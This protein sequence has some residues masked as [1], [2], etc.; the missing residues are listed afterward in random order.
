MADPHTEHARAKINLALH[1]LG[2]R[3]GGYHELDSI[4]GFADVAD[5][6][7]FFPADEFSL[8]VTGP[9]AGDVP[10]GEENIAMKAARMFAAAFSAHVPCRMV[11]EK[12][13]PVAAGIGGGSADA[14]AVM[15]GLAALAG[16]RADMSG[17]ALRLGADVPV[18]L[19]GR[20]CRMRGF[21]ERLEPIAGFS[22]RPAVLVN[23]GIALATAD[24]F[25]ELAH[26][27]GAPI[28][29]AADLASCR[30]DLTAPALRLAP[31]IADV[32][33][34]LKNNGATPVRMSGSG[35]TCFGLF[36]TMLDAEAAATAILAAQPGWWVRAAMIG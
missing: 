4:V 28:A 5:V 29:D 9:F 20:A 16:V 32:L 12:I 30:N 26:M 19:M 24:V 8:E 7:R 17:L 31:V 13:L 11:L 10:A 6:V 3:A 15:R 18:C 14:A 34:A 35:A 1:V 36:E 22:P 27:P 33:D 2:R 25:R 23:P 21:G